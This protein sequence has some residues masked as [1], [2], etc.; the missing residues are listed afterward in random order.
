MLSLGL[1][2]CSAAQGSKM[3]EEISMVVAY[4]AHVF[5][6]LRDEDCLAKLVAVSKPKAVVGVPPLPVMLKVMLCPGVKSF[7]EN[8]T[9]LCPFLFFSFSFYSL[10]PILLLFQKFAIMP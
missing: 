5:G 6:Q 3:M 9:I 10:V 2:S 4:D 1:W 7:F 8:F